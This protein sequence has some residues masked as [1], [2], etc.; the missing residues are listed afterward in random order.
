MLFKERNS[1]FTDEL[2]SAKDFMYK[3]D[4]FSRGRGGSSFYFA[5]ISKNAIQRKE[6]FIIYWWTWSCQR[7]MYEH[8]VFLFQWRKQHSATLWLYKHPAFCSSSKPKSSDPLVCLKSVPFR[9][10]CRS[11]QTALT[12]LELLDGDVEDALAVKGLGVAADCSDMVLE[13]IHAQPARQPRD[14]TVAQQV[15]GVQVPEQKQPR[16][17]C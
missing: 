17:H 4:V 16:T 2:G 6:V 13:P 8:D 3:C 11:L 1:E 14:V 12:A 5:Q 9:N 10:H 15:G 7:L